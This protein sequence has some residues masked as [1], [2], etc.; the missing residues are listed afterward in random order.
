MYDITQSQKMDMMMIGLE[1]LLSNGFWKE[2]EY[3]S[4][5]GMPIMHRMK[6]GA[7]ILCLKWTEE[8]EHMIKNVILDNE[9]MNKR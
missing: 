5:G 8:L 1:T 2:E 3:V 9:Y 7:D 4:A 6:V